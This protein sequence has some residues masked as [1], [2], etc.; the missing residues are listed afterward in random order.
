MD[1]LRFPLY[2][3]K[4][5]RFSRACLDGDVFLILWSFLCGIFDTLS[6]VAAQR[7]AA[8]E[9]TYEQEA[10]VVTVMHGEAR[11]WK[12][13]PSGVRLNMDATRTLVE[14]MGGSLEVRR[15]LD[16]VTTTLRVPKPHVTPYS[17]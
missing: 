13:W 11:E 15:G 17:P 3:H 2:G 6:E 7:F 16:G 14:N 5:P 4:W 9:V 8:V 10:L 12:K 1:T